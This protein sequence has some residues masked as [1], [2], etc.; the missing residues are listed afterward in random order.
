MATDGSLQTATQTA[1]TR[2][3]SRLL[4]RPAFILSTVRSGSTLLRCLLNSHT[5]LCSPSELH[6]RH[7]QVRLDGPYA[8]MAVHAQSLDARELEYMLWDR[9][10]AHILARS[11][12][13]HIVEK[14]PSNAKMWQRLTECWPDAIIIIL[15]RHPAAIVASIKARGHSEDRAVTVVSEAIEHLDQAAGSLADCRHVSYEDLTTDP[16]RCLEEVCGYL[17]VSFEPQM[18]NYGRHQH[19]PFLYG[20]GDWSERIQSGQIQR[21]QTTPEPTSPRLRDLCRRW[22]Y[23]PAD[24]GGEKL[25]GQHLDA[26]T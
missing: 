16:Q 8:E 2:G 25:N 10:L 22:G 7:I 6:L 3:P 24:V 13:T 17:G 21:P 20:V 9:L 18:L 11:G 4:K 15:R 14:S 19:G 5:Q 12:K 23:L 1:A 26:A